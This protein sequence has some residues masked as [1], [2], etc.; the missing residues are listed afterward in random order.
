MERQRV[1]SKVKK[2]RIKVKGTT[3]LVL[4]TRQ[5]EIDDEKK[6]L[7]KNELD[8]WEQKNWRRKAETDGKGNVTIPP[9]WFRSS[10]IN[11]CKV[12]RLVPHFATRKSETFTRYAESMVFDNS[13][14]KCSP[15]DLKAWGTYV[16]PQGGSS[17][18]YCIRPTLMEWESEFDLIDALGRMRLEE[19]KELLEYAGQI[20]GV[21]TARKLNYG[22]FEVLSVKE[23]K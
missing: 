17:Q 20:L 18:I 2:Y 4:D 10:F 23:L 21:G 16:S 15:K 9:R 8:D 13:T 22:R 5:R 11:A 6:K 19:L 12:T 7:K 14:F 3:P 1:D